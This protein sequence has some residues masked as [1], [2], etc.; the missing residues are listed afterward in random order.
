MII[1]FVMLLLDI[2]ISLIF[3]FCTPL[4][5][6]SP[7]F[8]F[9]LLAFI[10]V[11][12]VLLTALLALTVLCISIPVDRNKHRTKMNHFAL[13]IMEQGVFLLLLYGRA[14]WKV[15]GLEKLPKDAKF[16]LVHNHLSNF[17]QILLIFILRKYE[18]LWVTKPENFKIPAVGKIMALSGYLPLDRD[19]AANAVK[20]I[21]QASDY[22][23]SDTCSIGIC[24]EG[25]RS[26][27][28]KFHDFKPGSFKIA[29]W[30]EAPIVIG[31][32]RDTYK[33]AKRWP[34]RSTKIYFDV[35][36]VL[37][38]ESIKGKTTV[39][40][41]EYVHGRIQAFLDDNPTD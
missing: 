19:N 27:D 36:E 29:L 5:E 4:F 7:Y 13:W 11:I 34:W 15:N 38:Y 3:L 2:A 35:I 28:H 14:K 6:L 39:E 25:T 12:Y 1:A 33:I 32:I 30:G 20:T 40:I 23:K 37:P 8:A 9:L 31:C 10:P 22:I 17:D 18:M 21:R 24:P 26:K 41:S 16:L